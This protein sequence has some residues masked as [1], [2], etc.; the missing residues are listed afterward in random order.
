MVATMKKKGNG[1]RGRAV[2]PCD[3][4]GGPTEP[5]SGESRSCTLP[6]RF[7]CRFR[8]GRSIRRAAARPFRPGRPDRRKRVQR[9]GA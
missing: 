2:E 3:R 7:R 1:V 6:G 9:T 4:E 5:G 8:P